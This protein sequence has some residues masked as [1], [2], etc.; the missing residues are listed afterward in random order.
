DR[1]AGYRG[2]AAREDDTELRHLDLL[3]KF[4]ILEAGQERR[5]PPGITAGSQGKTEVA[6]PELAGHRGADATGKSAGER[7]RDG[8]LNL[9]EDIKKGPGDDRIAGR[10]GFHREAS[11]F[12][13]RREG[14]DFDSEVGFAANGQSP[15]QAA[16]SEMMHVNIIAPE[17]HLCAGIADDA[18]RCRIT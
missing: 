8:V 13:L 5:R 10:I 18:E 9:V 4:Q 7:T 16:A 1:D 6:A 2:R 12:F 17:D 11:D 14:A 15:R 3:I